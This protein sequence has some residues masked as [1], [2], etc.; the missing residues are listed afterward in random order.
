MLAEDT[1]PLGQRHSIITHS[2][3]S[4]TIAPPLLHSKSQRGEAERPTWMPRKYPE[5]TEV[6]YVIMGI[7]GT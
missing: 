4:T 6:N 2:T 1:K 3:A 5:V 7:M